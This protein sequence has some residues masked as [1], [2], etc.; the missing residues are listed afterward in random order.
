M[1]KRCGLKPLN[2]GHY[3]NMII[4]PASENPITN[5]VSRELDINLIIKRTVTN[6]Q[7]KQDL[8]VTNAKAQAGPPPFLS[9]R[10]SISSTC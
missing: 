2:P 9:G 4:L 6:N 10:S 3:L 7:L 5:G 1:E 8:E